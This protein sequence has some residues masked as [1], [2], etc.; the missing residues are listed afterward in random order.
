[1]PIIAFNTFNIIS[2]SLPFTKS[3]MYIAT[4]LWPLMF[5]CAFW[6]SRFQPP[7]FMSFQI[8]HIFVELQYCDLVFKN[9]ELWGLCGVY[10][11]M[12]AMNFEC[13][14][15]NWVE[16]DGFTTFLQPSW[17]CACPNIWTMKLIENFIL[18]H[19]FL[20][21][22]MSAL[23]LTWLNV[24]FVLSI[25]SCFVVQCG[26]VKLVFS[27]EWSVR[28]LLLVWKGICKCIFIL[29]TLK[30]VCI[31]FCVIMPPMKITMNFTFQHFVSKFHLNVFE[32]VVVGSTTTRASWC[33]M[34]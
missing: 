14:K 5:V 20:L 15:G 12:C 2:F 6:D 28:D 1:M 32:P 33:F 22:Y 13:W 10:V 34:F 31:S 8:G 7:W 26:W 27:F 18:Q 23:E 30:V 16:D 19:L 21:S 17:S 4:I 9:L 25:C 3:V 24:L 11:F 29:K